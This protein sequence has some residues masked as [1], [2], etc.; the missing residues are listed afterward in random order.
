[1]INS[2]AVSGELHDGAATS[3]LPHQGVLNRRLLT[4]SLALLVI[5]FAFHLFAVNEVRQF[6]DL[7]I[8]HYDSVGSLTFGYKIL[9]AYR[10]GGYI[11]AFEFVAEHSASAALSLTQAYFAALFSPVL[12]TTPESLQLYNTLGVA[13]ALLGIQTFCLRAGLSAAATIC[14]L[15]LFFLPDGLWW[16][17]FGLLDYRRDPGM[18]GFLVGAFFF[19]MALYARP[20]TDRKAVAI[21]SAFG[22]VA[23]L[24]AISRDSAPL[25]VVAILGGPAAALAF[26]DVHVYGIRHAA[27]R[28]AAAVTTAAP[29]ALI[30]LLWFPLIIGRL[31][32]PLVAYGAG[33]DAWSSLIENA[34]LELELIVGTNRQISYYDKPWLTA[35]AMGVLAVVLLGGLISACLRRRSQ[36]WRVDR[37]PARIVLILLASAAWIFLWQH[38]FLSLYVKWRPDMPFT[39]V[40]PPYLPS[41][42][43]FYALLAALFCLLPRVM[44]RGVVGRV[45][46]M[47]LISLTA[48]GIYVLTDARVAARRYE[49]P[50]W[51]YAANERI[52]QIVASRNRPAVFAE[53]W[54]EGVKIPMITNRAV[55]MGTALPRRMRFLFDGHH[56]DTGIAAPEDAESRKRL[57]RAMDHAARC[58][59][60][61]I[62]VTTNLS[63][64]SDETA[65]RLLFREGAAMVRTL[66]EESKG[67]AAL[68]I[69]AAQ[70]PIL[71]ID[72]T[73]RRLCHSG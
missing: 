63:R 11:A 27:K 58:D 41:L 19:L 16:W 36:A 28:I 13:V 26:L 70:D 56:Y 23:G 8:P 4:S 33:T 14:M 59:A 10:D 12:R 15:L 62:I 60:D 6:Y 67:Q 64:Y 2:A 53:L 17:D 18:F 61:Y 40:A 43:G 5:V 25:Y 52:A 51:M 55:Q 20:R 44:G 29:F 72:N 73:D 39:V 48:L 34:T 46:A 49:T 71:V 47:F 3:S 54:F 35:A 24:A 66:V 30:L 42:I 22:L 38:L 9:N 50:A 37:P 68:Q 21:S 69:N 31:S 57:L 1:M 7:N 45:S 65:P 32:D